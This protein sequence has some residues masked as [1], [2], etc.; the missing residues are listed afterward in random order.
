MKKN[1]K[2][3]KYNFKIV[4]IGKL[5]ELILF[6]LLNYIFIYLLVKYF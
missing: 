1:K 2:F 3:K 6:L 4:I 5:I